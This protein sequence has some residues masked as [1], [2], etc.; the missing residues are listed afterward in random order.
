MTAIVTAAA[1][2]FLEAL[3]E[4]LAISDTRYEQ[5]ETSYE[6]LGTWLNR[7]ASQ[8][9]TFDP[10]VYVQ[11][12]FGLGTVIKPLHEDEE[13]DVD[14][15]CELKN[16]DKGDLSQADLKELLRVELEAYRTARSI[17]KPLEEKRRCWTLRYADGAQFHMD[18]VPA[19]TDGDTMR[20]ILEAS[21][22]DSR[23]A[24]TAIAITDTDRVDYRILT[25]DWP[26]SNPKGYVQWFK[27]QMA[28]VLAK[29]KKE[30]AEAAQASVESIPDYR[31]RTSLQSA[32]MILKRHRDIMYVKDEINACPISII[33]TTLA[34][35][36]YGGEER[37]ADA[38]VSI[39]TGMDS[40]ILRD[41]EGR[42]FIANPTDPRENFADKWVKH[43]EREE[44]FYTWLA[45]AQR[46]F[47]AAAELAD[48]QLIRETLEDH[49]GSDLAKRAEARSAGRKPGGGLLRPAAAAVATA[50]P[51]LP[52]FGDVP[53]TPSTP[54]GF[55]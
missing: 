50:A 10:A 4:E 18:V 45:Q 15:V 6:S 48:R 14:A 33:I 54:K 2:D 42:A 43:P 13:Y 36:A 55:A 25:H 26:H 20:L 47:Q 41:A 19:I 8:I 1:Q 21:H 29:R 32:I 34:A 5:A 40:F 31:V 49:L 38:L 52:A 28:P 35:H 37:I 17:E 12:S 27:A 3:A 39:L 44:A 51:A 46:D 53:R 24:D 7:P 9:A 30:L 16:L 23:W 22:Q 11:G